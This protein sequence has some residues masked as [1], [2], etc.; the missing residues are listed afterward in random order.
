MTTVR[1]MAI[2]RTDP[3]VAASEV[4]SL[5][6]YLDFHR[7]TLLMKTDGLSQEQLAQTHP[8]SA[9]TLGGLL[10]HA[11]LDDDWWFCR[12]FEGRETEPGGAVAKA[13]SSAC[14]G[15]CCT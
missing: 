6:G 4:D 8:P 12:V 2:S 3:P 15:R 14:G 7:D 5:R 10:R 13:R 9:L 1:H 11:A